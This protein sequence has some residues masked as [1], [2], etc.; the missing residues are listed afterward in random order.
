MELGYWPAIST[1]PGLAFT[2]AFMNWME[3]LLSE[4]Q[5]AVQD[6][7]SAFELIVKEKLTKVNGR[8]LCGDSSIYN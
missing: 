2:Q 8:C 7:S 6:F 5:V 3:A 4:C 1:R